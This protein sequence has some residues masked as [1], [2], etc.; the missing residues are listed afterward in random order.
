VLAST[1]DELE[2]VDQSI[3]RIEV[4]LNGLHMS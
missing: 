4:V 3:P 1:D 2:A